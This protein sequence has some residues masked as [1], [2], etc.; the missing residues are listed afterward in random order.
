MVFWPAITP[1]FSPLY[2]VCL[3]YIYIYFDLYESNFVCVNIIYVQLVYELSCDFMVLN[4]SS[5][6]NERISGLLFDANKATINKASISLY[7]EADEFANHSSSG[8]IGRTSLLDLKAL[9]N[10]VADVSSSSWINHIW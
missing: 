8:S 5:L 7:C 1:F 6:Y 10:L 2:F 9:T 4:L 3:Y